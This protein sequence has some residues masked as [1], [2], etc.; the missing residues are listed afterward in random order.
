MGRSERIHNLRIARST[1][2]EDLPIRNATA[3]RHIHTVVIYVTDTLQLAGHQVKLF[4]RFEQLFTPLF[5]ANLGN[6][7]ESSR[8]FCPLRVHLIGWIFVRN[9]NILHLANEGSL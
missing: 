9:R 6:F 8:S 3:V 2:S 4:S 1:F 5:F 7:E